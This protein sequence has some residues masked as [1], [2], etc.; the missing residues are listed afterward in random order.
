MIL[1]IFLFF[2]YLVFYFLGLH[3]GH[4]EVPRLGIQSDLQLLAYTTATAMPDPSHV[5]DIYHSS[6]Q[7]QILNPLSN[8]RDR[9]H[10]LMDN[11]WI[12][13]PQGGLLEVLF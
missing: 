3:L 4:M 10:I 12:C 5:C 6:Q 8:A 1:P 2:I 7:H 13:L 11:S 9:T